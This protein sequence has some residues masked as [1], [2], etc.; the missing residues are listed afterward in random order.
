MKTGM[1]RV[2]DRH[3]PRGAVYAAFLGY[4][5]QIG[6]THQSI[7]MLRHLHGYRHRHALV[8]KLP[9]CDP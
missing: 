5:K 3:F 6:S 9:S 2:N 7:N 4:S 1:L 8:P